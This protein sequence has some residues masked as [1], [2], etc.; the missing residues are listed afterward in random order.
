[1][2]RQFPDGKRMPLCTDGDEGGQRLKNVM[3]CLPLVW[4]MLLAETIAVVSEFLTFSERWI[5][6]RT[7]TPRSGVERLA[8]V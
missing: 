5:D 8:E 4:F 1:M 6:D 2:L 3:A 7:D